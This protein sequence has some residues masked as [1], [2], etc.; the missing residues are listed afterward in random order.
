[1]IHNLLPTKSTLGWSEA[2]F[3]SFITLPGIIQAC[4]NYRE[5]V[6]CS[7]L[8]T[9]RS[10]S[11]LQ[12]ISSV[13]LSRR[14]WLLIERVGSWVEH[15]SAVAL[16]PPGHGLR[17]CW[18]LQI[19]GKMGEAVSLEG[20][21]GQYKAVPYPLASTPLHMQRLSRQQL[22]P[23]LSCLG[24]GGTSQQA[25]DLE[26]DPA[27]SWRQRTPPNLVAPRTPLPPWAV[28]CGPFRVQCP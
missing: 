27:A 2:D 22:W 23:Q 5:A 11:F 8:G 12:S 3:S 25:L 21:R 24:R 7:I 1:M 16:C 13:S 14:T 26:P 18:D 17:G 9:W 4:S 10:F 6:N 20:L 15:E 28:M 19:P